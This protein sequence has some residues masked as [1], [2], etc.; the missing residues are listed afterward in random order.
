MRELDVLGQHA[1]QVQAAALFGV[2]V[3]HRRLERLLVVA[4]PAVHHVDAAGGVLD[5]DHHLVLVGVGGVLH[6][7][8]A[9]LGEGQFDVVA[10]VLDHAQGV[11]GRSDD[12]PA[13]GDAR[14][15]AG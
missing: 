9:G 15:L 13:D 11:Q 7:V 14:R 3:R 10:D 2:G 4:V 8:R 1:D 6:D 12:S 5:A